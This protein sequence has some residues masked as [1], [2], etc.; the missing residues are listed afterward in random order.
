MP[1]E[2]YTSEDGLPL[3]SCGNMRK[4]HAAHQWM[5]PREGRVHCWGRNEI[6]PD[7][8]EKYCTDGCD[9]PFCVALRA[10]EWPPTIMCQQRWRTIP[11]EQKIVISESVSD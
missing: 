7:A 4:P 6:A 9:C 3:R 5:H 1:L 11:H 2:N 8:V 10:G